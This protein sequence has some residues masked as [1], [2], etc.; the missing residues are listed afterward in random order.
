M[1]AEHEKVD[2]IPRFLNIGYVMTRPFVG[3]LSI[4]DAPTGQSSYVR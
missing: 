3:V 2:C 1:R 4:S